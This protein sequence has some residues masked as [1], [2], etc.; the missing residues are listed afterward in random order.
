KKQA[1]CMIETGVNNILGVYRTDTLY[2]PS[3][4]NKTAK[5][6]CESNSQQCME[7]KLLISMFWTRSTGCKS[8]ST[9]PC[10]VEGRTF[11]FLPAYWFMPFGNNNTY[12]NGY[13]INDG[14]SYAPQ[15]PWY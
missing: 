7:V 6:K 1:A 14:Q 4:P 10:A 12:Y 2:D 13:V 11:G 5:G 3:Y 15:M 8:G 9:P